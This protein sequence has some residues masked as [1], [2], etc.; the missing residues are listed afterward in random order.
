MIRPAPPDKESVAQTVKVVNRLG[1]NRLRGGK[2][3]EQTLGAAAY[4]S[5]DMHVRIEARSARQNE[6]TQGRQFLVGLIHLPLKLLNLCG[7]NSWLSRMN[8]LGQ[9]GQNRAEIEELVLD[10]LENAAE[11]LQAIRFAAQL[12][13]RYA[14][15]AYKRIQLI[16][17]SVRFDPAIGL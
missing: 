6:R 1:R 2:P 10:S 12:L 15:C 16:D 11:S 8:I 17:G 4:G 9:G 14:G 7:C 3:N 5:A 13:G